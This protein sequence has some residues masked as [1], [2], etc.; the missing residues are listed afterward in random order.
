MFSRP[1][2]R[3]AA[4]AATTPAVAPTATVAAGPSVMPTIAHSIGT[5]LPVTAPADRPNRTGLP[6][7][8]KR[9]IEAL[10][11]TTLDDIRVHR[12][13][14]KPGAVMAHAYAQ[15]SHIHL[16][17]G[18]ERHL[19]HEAWHV[20]Q[21]KQGRVRPTMQLMGVAVNDH[22]GLEREADVMGARAASGDYS[23]ITAPIVRQGSNADTP[24][25]RVLIVKGSPEYRQQVQ[26]HLQKLVGK[27][28]GNNRKYVTVHPKSGA[29]RVTPPR[30][31]SVAGHRLLH[32]IT[33]S[34][35]AVTLRD[36]AQGEAV[37]AEPQRPRSITR[38][39]GDVASD[40]WNWRAWGGTQQLRNRAAAGNPALGAGATIP[41]NTALPNVLR[42][43]HVDNGAGGTNQQVSPQHLILGHELIHADH[44]Q[45]GTGAFAAGGGMLRGTYDYPRP[46]VAGG[47]DQEVGLREEM[48][49]VG[50]PPAAALDPRFG[51][52]ANQPTFSNAPNADAN[53]ITENML[54][55]Q[56][57]Q[58]LRRRYPT[59]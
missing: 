58:P 18:Q 5:T 48:N 44:Y 19:P 20:V 55:A 38:A 32:R 9:G 4:S 21:Q 13:S 47:H 37:Q 10:S 46:A 29:V 16:A 35:H 24:I 6:D 22:Q 45:R 49:N 33:A 7:D 25:Q 28:H 31:K 41:Y 52:L 57:G 12:N 53:A 2:Q 34:P 50:I 14:A 26:A 36:A 42:L 1:V 8:L 11:G 17:R 51:I 54:R 40:I 43:T 39:I 15:G 30:R 3:L 27:G 56:H 23:P 59:A